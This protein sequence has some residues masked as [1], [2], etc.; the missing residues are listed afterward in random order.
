MTIDRPTTL[1]PRWAESLLCL[2]LKPEDRESVSGDL[3]EEYRQA[4]VPS[5]GAGA[6]RWY[7]REVGGYVLRAIAPWSALIAAICVTR[8]LFD[9]LA[10][11]HYTPGVIALR[12]AVMSW[13]LMGT[14][15]SCGAW[16]AWRTGHPRAGLVVAVLTATLG[17]W[18]ATAGSLLCLAKWHDPQIIAAIEGSGG[19]DEAFAI[20]PVQ[21]IL[22][23]AVIGSAGALL[24]KLALA[25]YGFSRPNTNSA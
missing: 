13:A 12:S 4:K 1:P 5:L 25:V 24:G 15:F 18:L 23:A 22:I 20:L 10:P 3:L 8:Y 21:L 14:F 7:V 6:N 19:F 17:G 9:T 11:I 2:L 16:Q